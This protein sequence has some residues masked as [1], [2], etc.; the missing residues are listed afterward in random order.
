VLGGGI[1]RHLQILNVLEAVTQIAEKRVA[2][3]LQHATLADD[4]PDAL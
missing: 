2:E 3:V 1:I 4:V